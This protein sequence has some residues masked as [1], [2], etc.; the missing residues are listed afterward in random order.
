MLSW[1]PRRFEQRPLLADSRERDLAAVAAHKQL[2][3][4]RFRFALT[5]AVVGLMLIWLPGSIAGL[6][7][8]DRT[9]RIVAL[10]AADGIASVPRLS[11]SRLTVPLLLLAALLAL[12]ALAALVWIVS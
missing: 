3:R 1:L 7:A 9:S 11:R 8:D 12:A 6:L 10:D 5:A 2:W 4:T